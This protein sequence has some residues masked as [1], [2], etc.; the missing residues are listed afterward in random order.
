MYSIIELPTLVP[1]PAN[2]RHPAEVVAETVGYAQP[3]DIN[4]KDVAVGQ[5]DSPLGRRHAV[6]WKDGAVQDLGSLYTDAKG[7]P[8]GFS[9]AF[10]INGQGTV[11]GLCARD[12]DPIAFRWDGIQM[13][14]LPSPV[15]YT[16]S[17]ARSINRHGDIAGFAA[18]GRYG[19]AC[20]WYADGNVQVIGLPPA[21]QDW[22]Y[23]Y[24]VAVSITDSREV[25]IV[26]GVDTIYQPFLW[27][28]GNWIT[29][30][31]PGEF[32]TYPDAVN[33]SEIVVGAFYWW[34]PSSGLHSLYG[35][36]P[37]YRDLALRDIN[38]SGLAVGALIEEFSFK[39]SAAM[40]QLPGTTLT[41]LTSLIDPNT[42]WVLEDADGVNQRGAVV[43]TG[44][45][46]GRQ[47]A[48]LL[49]PPPQIPA[50]WLLRPGLGRGARFNP[51]FPPIGPGGPSPLAGLAGLTSGSP[52]M[53]ARR[54]LVCAARLLDGRLRAEVEH[55]L[56]QLE[57]EST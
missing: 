51:P 53:R 28:G 14:A 52:R 57:S 3:L 11:V 47:A 25:L 37:P 35:A 5:S 16:H 8:D 2:A 13:T 38:D 33:E 17:G 29:L 26:A 27:T 24:S 6:Q 23:D 42:G 1:N 50:S 21:L 31:P 32:G 49:R 43:G 18:D 41:D 55:I 36:G 12:D 48:Y 22:F 40:L 44:K 10:A 30:A 19:R 54:A 20:V 4:N 39:E 45:R 7:A 9:I 46:F 56:R 34:A 15:G